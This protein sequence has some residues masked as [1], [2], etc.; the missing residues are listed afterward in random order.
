MSFRTAA[1]RPD[2][3]TGTILVVDDEQKTRDLFRSYL[4]LEGY[5]VLLADTGERVLEIRLP[6]RS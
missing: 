4:E 3:G 1:R 2:V 6:L 5:S